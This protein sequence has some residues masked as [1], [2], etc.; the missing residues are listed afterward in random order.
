MR[1]KPVI[2]QQVPCHLQQDAT[3]WYSS[4]RNSRQGKQ[5]FAFRRAT[6]MKA[7]LVM[8]PLRPRVLWVIKL[9]PD[10]FAAEP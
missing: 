7:G 10:V 5:T 4:G 2:L 8:V 9:L 3:S 6:F 1:L